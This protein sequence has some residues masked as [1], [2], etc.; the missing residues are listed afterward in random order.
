MKYK[1]YMD[2]KVWCAA[3]ETILEEHL[4]AEIPDNI[5]LWRISLDLETN[6]VI[7]K[8]PSLT[9]S[10]AELEQ[11]KDVAAEAKAKAEAKAEA[12]EA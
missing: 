12:K 8:Y 10:E 7:I 11:D 6:T 4:E 2:G 9:D 3:S 1:F 5:A